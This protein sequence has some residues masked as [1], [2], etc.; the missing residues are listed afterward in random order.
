MMTVDVRASEMTLLADTFGFGAA[1]FDLIF[2]NTMHAAFRG[3]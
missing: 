1:D 3:R 2:E